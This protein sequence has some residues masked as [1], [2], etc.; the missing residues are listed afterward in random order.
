MYFIVFHS[1][2]PITCFGDGLDET[3]RNLPATAHIIS[4]SNFMSADFIDV[5]MLYVIKGS[6]VANFRYT[7]FWVAIA[8]VVVAIVV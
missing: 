6:L 5:Y 8:V 1:F 3:H 7:N 4:S 2:N